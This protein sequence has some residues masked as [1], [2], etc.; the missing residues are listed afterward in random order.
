MTNKTDTDQGDWEHFPEH[1]C[2][3]FYNKEDLEKFL[4]REVTDE[5]F[6][7]ASSLDCKPCSPALKKEMIKWMEILFEE[8]RQ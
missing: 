6:G 4:R 8:R 5:E 2:L 3:Y 1:F 7:V